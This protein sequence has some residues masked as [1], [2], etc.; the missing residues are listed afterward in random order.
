MTKSGPIRLSKLERGGHPLCG[1]VVPRLGEPLREHSG[2][3]NRQ[4]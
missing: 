1:D 2:G 3:L 4:W